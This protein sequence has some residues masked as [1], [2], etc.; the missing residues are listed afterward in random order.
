MGGG[1]SKSSGS[2]GTSTTTNDPWSGQVPYLNQIFGEAQNLYNSGNMAPEYY[3][4]D[5]V[6][7]RDPYT[8]QAIQMQADRAQNG[9]ALNQNAQSMVN[10]TLNGDFLNN[11]QYLDSAVQRAIGQSNAGVSS[12]YAQ[13]GRFGSGAHAAAA[14]DAAGNIASQMYGNAYNAERQNM[15]QAAGLAPNLAQQDYNDIAALSEAGTANE[16]YNQQLINADIDRYNYN[17]ARDLTAL[18]NYMGLI[19]GNYGGTSKSTGTLGASNPLGNTLGGAAAGAGIGGYFGNSGYGALAGGA[20][21]AL[22]NFF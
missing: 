15:M 19:Q 9:S 7:G 4:G 11:N 2:A 5:T 1:K 18:Q 14:Q 22:S 13:A 10:S 12:N 21:G 8:E 6:A 20:L 16:N 17:S 3:E